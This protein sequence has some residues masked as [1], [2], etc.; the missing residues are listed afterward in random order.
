MIRDIYILTL[1]LSM[2]YGECIITGCSSQI[3]AEEPI[4]SDCEYLDWYACFQYSECGNYGLEEN[5]SWLTT[6]SFLDCLGSFGVAVGC[7]DSDACNYDETATIYDGSCEYYDECLIC[8][9]DGTSCDGTLL[10]P[11]EYSSIQTAIDA[12][13]L[14]PQSCTKC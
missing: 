3:C 14:P 7:T 11:T 2:V 9:G 5:C 4:S 12:A 10:V 13:G 8:N 1:L 6:D